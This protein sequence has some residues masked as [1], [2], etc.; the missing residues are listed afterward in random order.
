MH[1]VRTFGPVGGMERYV[2]ETVR[3][4]AGRGHQVT[5]MCRSA[6]ETGGDTPAVGRIIL[7][8]PPASR[9]WQ[10]RLHFARAVSST[11]AAS[12]HSRDYDIIHS[13]ENTT[14]Q[15]VSTEHGPCTLAGLRR[16]PWKF[17]D[18]SALRNLALERAKFFCPSLVGVVSC[19][20]RVERSIV[21]AYPLLGG[22]LRAV[23][24]PA[25]SYIHPLGQRTSPGFVLG[26]I[27]ADWRRKG[28]PK[29]LEIFRLLHAADPRWTMVIAGVEAAKL[30]EKLVRR[31]PPGAALAGRVEPESFFSSIDVL[32]HPASDEP[33]GMVVGEALSAGVPAVVSDR[34]GCTGH[35]SADGLQ[36]L[37]LGSELGEWGRACV[38]ARASQARLL[39]AR[40]WAEVAAQHE[41]LYARLLA[42]RSGAAR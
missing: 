10:D 32:L 40:T 27:G 28:L 20:S 33:F 19:S 9:G 34:C 25:D 18:F 7:N 31:L 36:V 11:F 15:D 39:S 22:K 24:P 38:E 1:I 2:Y 8:T 42:V 35:L 3:A 13:H 5:V 26:F 21:T 4:L 37:S 14:V 23:I 16:R 30:P 29:A 6:Q 41:I 12:S 17:A